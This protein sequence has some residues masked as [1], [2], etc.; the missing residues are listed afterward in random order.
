[1]DF[2]DFIVFRGFGGSLRDRAGG[3]L[4]GGLDGM[5]EPENLDAVFIVFFANNAED[6]TDF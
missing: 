3:V 6:F 5:E 1:M 4:G 2:V